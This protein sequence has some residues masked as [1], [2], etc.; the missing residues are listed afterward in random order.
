MA[1]TPFSKDFITFLQ[2]LSANNNR[3][4][5][6]ANKD[7]FK[8]NVEAPFH[9]FVNLMINR[10]ESIQDNLQGLTSKQCVFRI[11]RDVR[12]SKDKSPYK[13]HM[14]ALIGPD[15]RKDRNNPGM[16]LHFGGENVEMYSGVYMPDKSQL[17]AIRSAIA[18]DPSGFKKLYSAKKFIETFGS[19]Q[20]DKNKRLNKPF[21]ELAEQ[22]PLLF[23]KSFYYCKK[24]PA[25]SILDKDFDKTLLKTYK[26]AQPMNAFLIDALK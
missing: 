17:E 20:G 26:V 8:A 4:W 2:E 6:N 16:Y 11:Y 24:W 25:K 3:D 21:S 23:N 10:L 13:T 1:A 9:E 12:F 22:E 19:V 15:G 7:R 5:F 18:A 14:A